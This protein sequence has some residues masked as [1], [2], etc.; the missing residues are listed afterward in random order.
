MNLLQIAGGQIWPNFLPIL[1]YRPEHVVFLT[2]ADPQHGYRDAIAQM[3]SA[4]PSNGGKTSYT[5]LAIASIQ[6]T[7][8]ECL[9]ALQKWDGRS[10]DLI[11]LTGG[12]KAMSAAAYVY[13]KERQIPS[14]HLDTRRSHQP[15]DDFG[16]GPHAVPFPDLVPISEGL[17]VKL[18]LQALGFSVPS[19]FKHPQ[20]SHLAFARHAAAIRSDEAAGREIADA[21]A[22]LRECLTDP[23]NGKFLRKG[24]LREALRQPI[25]ATRGSAWHRYLNAAADQGILE[26]LDPPEEFLLVTMDPVTASTEELSSLAEANFKLL[27]GIWFELAVYDYLR[28]KSSFSDIC[29]SVEADKTTDPTASS[30]GETD[31]VAFNHKTLNLHFI[32]CKTT[33]PHA[34]PL[35]HIQGL[36][37]RATKE[38]GE[39]SK[40]ELWIFRPRTPQ[41]RADLHNHCKEQ[42]VILRVYT[43]QHP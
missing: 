1:G 24:K 6:P 32:S 43:E 35:D 22:K 9:E 26:R 23:Q 21:I 4:I 40:A 18:A 41:Q 34:T 17:N 15:F 3:M 37:R 29:W 42:N 7:F 36:R 2:S 8:A 19:S 20:E 39:F 33:G 30:K 12:T 25:P 31:L 10:I 11:N 13:A 27:E 16:S 28:S 14:F 38:G 5:V